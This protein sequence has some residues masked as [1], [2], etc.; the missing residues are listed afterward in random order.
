MLL[1]VSERCVRFNLMAQRQLDS[2]CASPVSG[3]LGQDGSKAHCR[4]VS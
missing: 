2:E 4:R 3:Q 1:D